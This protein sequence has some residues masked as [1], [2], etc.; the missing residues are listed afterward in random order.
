MWKD[1]LGSM[2]RAGNNLNIRA[3]FSVIGVR[4]LKFFVKSFYQQHARL[5]AEIDMRCQPN[6]VVD[7]CLLQY[8]SRAGI[9]PRNKQ[10]DRNCIDHRRINLD[11][12]AFAFIDPGAKLKLRQNFAPR[13]S[14]A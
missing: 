10:T 14:L 5:Q 6:F 1:K 12:L 2:I 3:E 7:A 11:E 13:E 9:Q 4:K 8:K